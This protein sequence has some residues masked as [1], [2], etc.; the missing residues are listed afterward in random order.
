MDYIEREDLFETTPQRF[1]DWLYGETFQRW[2][3]NSIVSEFASY[4]PEPFRVE[5]GIA[6]GVE[7]LPSDSDEPVTVQNV[8]RFWMLQTSE[9]P[10]VT[11]IRSKCKTGILQIDRGATIDYQSAIACFETLW[12]RVYSQFKRVEVSEA[13]RSW[14]NSEFDASSVRSIVEG[15]GQVNSEDRFISYV[16]KPLFEVMGYE[17]V[18]CL[19]HTGRPE[20]GKDIVFHEPD[21]LGGDTYYAVVAC[22]GK[23]HANS[24]KTRVSGHYQKIIDQVEKCFAKPYEDYDKKGEFYIDKVIVACSANITDEAQQYFREWEKRERRH[25]I[26]WPAERIASYKLRLHLT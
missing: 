24:S 26:F 9:F 22:V 16:L 6:L 5:D 7:L 19:H 2:P 1:R 25:L 17:G 8:I 4:P 18:T 3:D 11:H 10:N 21:R 12:E 20:Y 23:I 15:L 13:D 14:R